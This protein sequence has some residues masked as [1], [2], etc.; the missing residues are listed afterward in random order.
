MKDIT[1]T[2]EFV[3]ISVLLSL[4]VCVLLVGVSDDLWNLWSRPLRSFFRYHVA[5]DYRVIISLVDVLPAGME[6]RVVALSRGTLGLFL[7][8]KLWMLPNEWFQN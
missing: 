8:S 1:D 2:K 5:Q 4:V 3:T 7:M 6:L